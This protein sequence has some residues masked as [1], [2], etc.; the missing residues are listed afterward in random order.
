MSLATVRAVTEGNIRLARTSPKT[1]P[2]KTSTKTLHRA[3]KTP[4]GF[5][6]TYTLTRKQVKNVNLRV[7]ADGTVN[8]SASP[9]ISLSFIDEFVLSRADFIIEALERF[10]TKN[11]LHALPSEFNSGDTVRILGMN[12]PLLIKQDSNESVTLITKDSS[13]NPSTVNIAD[14]N[15][16]IPYHAVLCIALKNPLHTQKKRQLFLKWKATLTETIFKKL[17]NDGYEVFQ[18]FNVPEPTLRITEMKS[19]WGT[20]KPC[21]KLITLN[22]RL[23]EYPLPAIKYVVWHEYNHFLHM[24]HSAAFHDSLSRVMP[25]WKNRMN[26]LR[27]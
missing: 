21:D 24:D 9:Q 5:K 3:V 25:D 14:H 10:N 19:R 23:I 1:M 11:T 15:Y 8:V 16:S 20:C 18:H 27:H 7:K 2:N 22:S 17:I 4:A 26:M 13:G 6:I 12:I